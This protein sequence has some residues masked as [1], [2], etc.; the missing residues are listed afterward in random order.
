MA[1]AIYYFSATGNSL[2]VAKDLAARFDNVQIIPIA[3]AL[4]NN[5]EQPFDVVGIV[6]PVY[7]FGLP[8][9]VADFLKQ[10]K[11]KPQAYIFAVATL[12]G[13]PGLAHTQTK[14][15][16]E[17]R[18]FLL[19]AAF[20][21]LMPG[22][23]TPLYGA[24]D[25]EK[26]EEMFKKEKL[27]INTIVAAVKEQKRGIMEEKPFL[28]NFLFNK[29]LYKGGT[30]QIPLSGRNFWVTEACTKCGLCAKVCPVEN[31]EL[32]DSKP[33][34]L[35]HCQHC[36]ACLQWC[37]VEAIQYKKSTLGR[38]RYRHPAITVQE[39][40]NQRVSSVEGDSK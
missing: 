15:I 21:V 17:S 9:I 18:G 7:M 25:K 36:M 6:Y 26:Q 1:T 37:P 20:S 30:K 23:Y 39:I 32:V 14:E 38:K 5:F 40:E 27:R 3:K 16:L 34:W 11:I 24:I 33:Q 35:T 28:L 8:L 22:N 13:L 10:I 4:K 19:S 2:T 12:G 29:L 31:I